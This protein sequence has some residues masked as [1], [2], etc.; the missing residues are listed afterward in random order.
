MRTRGHATCV[1]RRKDA[2][3]HEWVRE[4]RGKGT[5]GVGIRT[6]ANLCQANAADARKKR[7]SQK[8]TKHRGEN[9]EADG[10]EPSSVRAGGG[11]GEGE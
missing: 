10:E 3:V 4:R 6:T 11:G 1:S 8:A 7:A 5:T 9:E 2:H